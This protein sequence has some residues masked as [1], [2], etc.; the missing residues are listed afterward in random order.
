MLIKLDDNLLGFFT[1][2]IYKTYLYIFGHGMKHRVHRMS[3]FLLLIGSPHPL[4]GKRVL[5]PPPPFGS[6]RG[7]TLACG[8]GGGWIQF[9]RRDMTLWYSMYTLI[10]L[11]NEYI[12]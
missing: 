8:G 6:K 12:V 3:G 9:R 4:T 2:E 11:R 7:D 1:T 5:L 10:P